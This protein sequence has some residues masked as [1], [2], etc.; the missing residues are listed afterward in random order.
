MARPIKP[1]VATTRREPGD[2]ITFDETG[3][4]AD[5]AEVDTTLGSGVQSAVSS[6]GSSAR[7]R[8]VRPVRPQMG[9][10]HPDGPHRHRRRWLAPVPASGSTGDTAAVPAL[11]LWSSWPRRAGPGRVL[12]GIPTAAATPEVIPARGPADI[13]H[14]RQL[15]RR[16]ELQRG[17]PDGQPRPPGSAS[18]TRP[19]AGRA[20]TWPRS[21]T[22]AN[23]SPAWIR[24]PCCGATATHR[25]VGRIRH[26]HG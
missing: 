3:S 10:D 7:G 6:F 1:C 12:T 5:A 15:E 25:P 14:P 17:K 22:T 20:P 16:S 4:S 24:T 11:S 13:R 21:S 19:H 26:R 2:A 23:W 8:P 9:G 18:R